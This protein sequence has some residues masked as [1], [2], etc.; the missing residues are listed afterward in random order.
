M[1]CLPLASTKCWS[2]MVKWPGRRDLPLSG[3]EGN[4]PGLIYH[5]GSLP[6]RTLF[7]CQPWLGTLEETVCA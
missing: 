5:V 7:N 3:T 6:E 4:H 2:C 1:V